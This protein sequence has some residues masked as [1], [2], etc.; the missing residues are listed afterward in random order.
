MKKENEICYWMGRKLTH[1]QD[2]MRDYTQRIGLKLNPIFTPGFLEMEDGDIIYAIEL[3]EE[4][5]TESTLISLSSAEEEKPI[6]VAEQGVVG[7]K[8]FYWMGQNTPLHYLMVNYC[9]RTGAFYES[10]RFICIR[11]KRVINPDKTAD[12]LKMEDEDLIYASMK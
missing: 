1:F 6:L 2:L 9:D 11:D 4:T 8:L 12:D 10:L 7:D 5:I 3:T